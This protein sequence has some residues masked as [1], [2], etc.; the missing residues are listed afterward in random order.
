MQ[1]YGTERHLTFGQLLAL[2]VVLV[3]V[4]VVLVAVFKL[5]LIASKA[6]RSGSENARW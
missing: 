5:Q 2:V 4:V 1:C 3:V 6:V